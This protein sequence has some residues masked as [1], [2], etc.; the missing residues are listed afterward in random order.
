MSERFD[1]PIVIRLNGSTHS[2]A[3][4]SA[5]AELL[6]SV[7]WPGERGPVHRDAYETCLKVVEGHR[8]AVDGQKR[9]IE[10]ARDAGVIEGG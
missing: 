9:F 5:A 4:A 2:V 3:S 8:S 1:Q 10:A 7:D 6:A